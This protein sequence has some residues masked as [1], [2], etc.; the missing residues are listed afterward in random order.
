M[1]TCP[2][3]DKELQNQNN[4]CCSRSCAA[5]LARSKKI[6]KTSA[7]LWC[8]ATITLGGKYCNN[9]H[10]CLNEH[11]HDK[12]LVEYKKGNLE[13]LGKNFFKQMVTDRDGYKCSCCGTHEW[14]GKPIVL[15]LEHIDGNSENNSEEN[16]TLLCPNCHSQ[17][18]TFKG[19][20]RGNGRAARRKRYAEGK[21]Y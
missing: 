10:K 4:I 3:C 16:L 14:M 19:A 5:T 2:T 1:K 20:N 15:D 7:C 8:Q 17:T 9:N 13:G 12:R 6:I 21:S 18:P 11:K